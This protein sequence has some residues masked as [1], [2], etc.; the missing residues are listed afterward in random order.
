MAIRSN[1]KAFINSLLAMNGQ[2]WT[3]IPMMRD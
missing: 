3:V 1:V 2:Y